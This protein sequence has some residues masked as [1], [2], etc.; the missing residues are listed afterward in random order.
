MGNKNTSPHL[1]N[2]LSINGYDNHRSFQQHNLTNNDD[3]D[4]SCETSSYQSSNGKKHGPS[5]RFRRRRDTRQSPL[6]K[7]GKKLQSASSHLNVSLQSF[8]DRTISLFSRSFNFLQQSNSSSP[9][10]ETQQKHDNYREYPPGSHSGVYRNQSRRKYQTSSLRNPYRR[11]STNF[12]VR[13]H[14]AMFLPEFSIKGKVTEADFEVIDIIAR[15]AFGNVIKVSCNHNKQVYAMK[16]MSKSQIVKDNAVQQV[17]DEVTIAQSCLSHS[18][19]VHTHH[20]WQ[21]RRFLYIIT[22][23]VENGELLSLW[24]R[25]RRF[26][27]M[28]VKIYIA[29]VAMVLDYLHNKGIIYRDVK[30][31]NILLDEHGNIKMIDFGLSKWL[32]MGQ[33]TTTICGTLQYIAPEVL[34][35]RPYDHRVDWWSLG[36]LMYACLFGEYPVSATKDHISMA[37]KVLNHKFHFPLNGLDNKTDIKELLDHLLEKNPNQRLCSLDELRQTSFMST[38]SFDRIY[39][40]SYFPIAILMNTKTEW[41]NELKEHYGYQGKSQMNGNGNVYHSSPS[42]SRQTFYENLNNHLST[43]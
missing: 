27:E 8:G 37:N 34:S 15:G 20:Y 9:L 25:I 28:I 42:S 40:K 30:M 19:I 32:P 6:D 2:S 16:I 11:S 17:K 12:P 29:Q 22:D 21:S 10:C 35:V 4:N 1:I 3:T 26:P 36:I 43:K 18:F 38:I 33:R 31:E 13:G 7:K 39:S 41:Y 5:P 14:E 24:L 23:Y